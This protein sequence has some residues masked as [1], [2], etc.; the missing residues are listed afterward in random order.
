MLQP[1]RNPCMPLRQGG[2]NIVE[3]MV[4]V[5]VMGVMMALALPAMQD[6]IAS[7]R[8]KSA[9][10]EL[11]ADLTFAR[12]EAISRGVDVV[13]TSTTGTT[14]WKGGWSILETGGRTTLRQA[15]ARA[16]G[17]TFTGP[18]PSVTF[19]RTGRGTAAGTVQFS[20]VP[21]N[22]SAPEHQKRCLRLDP[23]GRVRARQEACS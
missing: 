19:D 23:S 11:N 13:V 15:D 3:L 16:S 14:D 22:A 7:Q 6:M 10:Y 4:V 8:V 1:R 20:I 18:G 2:F 12:S 21:T 17:L 5:V 9:S